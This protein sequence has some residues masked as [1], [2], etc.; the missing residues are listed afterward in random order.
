MKTS[1]T[2]RNKNIYQAPLV[3]PNHSPNEKQPTKRKRALPNSNQP[4][5][6]SHQ[7]NQINTKLS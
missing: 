7:N 4:I 1:K 3:S 2:Y 6:P 5:K